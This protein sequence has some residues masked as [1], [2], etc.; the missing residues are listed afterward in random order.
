MVSSQV[1]LPALI[2]FILT[3]LQLLL[4]RSWRLVLVALA[5][6]YLGVFIFICM[7]WTVKLALAKLISGW[8]A[9]VLLLV[10]V[11][12]SS[13]PLHE[14]ASPSGRLFRL[15]AACLIAITIIAST[16]NMRLWLPEVELILVLPSLV[17]ISMGLL[18]LSLTRLP[19]RA[20]LAMLTM[21]SGFEILYAAV[22]GSVMVAGFLAG[23]TLGMAMVGAYLIT[24]PDLEREST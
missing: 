15:L 11:G 6:Q 5:A 19:L 1:S 20:I 17:L 24:A 22:E 9:C 13:E 8:M 18:H 10:A 4:G 12:N 3:S 16:R 14:K 23:I 7:S 2:L 21:L